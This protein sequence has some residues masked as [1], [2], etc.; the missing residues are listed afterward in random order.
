MSVLPNHKISFD[1]SCMH[2]A[3]TKSQQL[4]HSFVDFLVHFAHF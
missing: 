3:C 2:G 4:E 1:V